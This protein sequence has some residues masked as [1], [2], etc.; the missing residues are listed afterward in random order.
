MNNKKTTKQKI[1]MNNIELTEEAQKK[2][3]KT[4]LN[5]IKENSK[6]LYAKIY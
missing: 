2:Q 3:R 1:P 4:R 6:E 5:D